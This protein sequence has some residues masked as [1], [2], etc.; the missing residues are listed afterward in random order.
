MSK[1]TKIWLTVATVFVLSGFVLFG[2]A[3]MALKWDFAAL[4]TAEYKT[5]EYEIAENFS[6]ISIKNGTTNVL[7]VPWEQTNVKVVC[8]ER[9]KEEHTVLVKDGRLS[10][11]LTDTRKWYEHIGISFAVPKITVY[12]PQAKYRT[13]SVKSS[14]GSINLEGIAVDS[15]DLS[16]STGRIT[17]ADVD[18]IGD[19]R[20]NV[21]TGIANVSDVR[22]K[23]IIS[24]GSTGDI[25]LENVIATQKLSVKRD[26]GDVIFDRCDAEEIYV[27]TDTG[28]VKGTLLSDKIYITSTSTGRINVPK[29]MSGGICDITTSTG[30]IS[31]EKANSN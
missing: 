28:N 30:N 6:D 27:E 8:Y 13:L 29:S 1:K 22:C 26:T 4:L 14:T 21:T 16:V 19:V 11:E 9:E 15:L 18:C 17:V 2:G 31:I 25:F 5:N 20:I 24:S 10:I 3:M 23:N 12:L 7:F